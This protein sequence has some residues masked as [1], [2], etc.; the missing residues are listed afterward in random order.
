MHPGCH[1]SS[2][3][4][5][6]FVPCLVDGFYPAVAASMAAV[7]QRLGLELDFPAGQTCCGQP[8]FNAGH[9]RAARKAAHHFINCFEDAAVI[10]G[11]SGSCVSMVRHHYPDLFRDEPGWRRRAECLARRTFEFSEF[12]VDVL[13]VADVGARG[14]GT[15]TYHDSCHLLRAL[16]VGAQPRRLIA[17]VDGIDFVE[18]P[19][20]DLCCG[21]GGSFAVKYPDIST[22][23]VDNKIDRI[24]AT[25]ADTVVG[26]DM[27]CLMNIDGRL[28]RR[29]LDLRVL[30]LAQL[31]DGALAPGGHVR[32]A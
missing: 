31:L 6:L 26:A 13:G 10:V 12:L 23:M 11:P 7:L 20:A 30:H 14:R 9:R 22:A 19:G 17:A 5:T 29:G 27:G 28:R 25:G 8:A 18:M 21:F 3:K 32:H 16:G 24:L 4:V 2:R 1:D 15:I